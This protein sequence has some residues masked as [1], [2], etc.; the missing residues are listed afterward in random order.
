MKNSQPNSQQ[1]N[2]YDW[3]KLTLE[4][5]VVFLGVTVGFL[6][7]NWRIQNQEKSL[8]QKYLNGFAQNIKINNTSLQ[9]AIE[10]DSLRIENMKPMILILQSGELPADSVISVFQNIISISRLEFHTDTY[11]EIINSGNLNIITN[12]QLKEKIVNYHISIDG[13][14]FVEDYF[15]N[16]HN[17][18]VLP[19]VLN[20]FNMLTGELNNLDII[21]TVK[22]SN[23]IA[24]YYSMLQQQLK[25]YK[26]LLVKSI[27]LRQIVE[28]NLS[29]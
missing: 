22:F 27:D 26:E 1:K 9:T 3:R 16:Y 23:V 17:T 28:G 18:F 6:L 5:I 25:V 15:H 7:N 2:K 24:S 10:T 14:K 21:E 4:L 19:F 20:E 29:K 12:F 8:E 11:Q 13:V